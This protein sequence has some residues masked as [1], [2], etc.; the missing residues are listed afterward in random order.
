MIRVQCLIGNE[1]VYI[2]PGDPVQHVHEALNAA[3]THCAGGHPQDHPHGEAG[4]SCPKEHEGE[5]WHGPMSGPR[6][7]GCTV[8][9]PVL[10]E[11]LPGA[12]TV[13]AA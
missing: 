5:C 12:A 13:K 1:A 2:N 9:R 8:C 6:P 3:C 7:A 10:I 4:S 11:L